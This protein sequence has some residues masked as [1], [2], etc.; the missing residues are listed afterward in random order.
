MLNKPIA[1]MAADVITQTYVL[2]KSISDYPQCNLHDTATIAIAKTL[3]F[4]QQQHIKHYD[5]FE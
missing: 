1:Y 5:D 2:R 4:I 3:G